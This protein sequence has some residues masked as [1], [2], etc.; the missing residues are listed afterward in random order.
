MFSRTKSAPRAFARLLA[1]ALCLAVWPLA[2]QA[3]DKSQQAYWAG[4]AYTADA[5]AVQVTTPH[6][7]AVLEKR[8]LIP[9]NQTLAQALKRRAPANLELIDQPVAMLDGTTSAVVL[10]AALDR[11]L[12]SVE[13]IGDQYKVLVE[14]A[15]QAL[16]FDFRERQVI[17]SY[18]LTLQRIDVQEYRPDSDDIDAIVADLL[19]GGAD[20]SLSQVLATTLAQAKLPEAA[21]RR[22]QVGAVTLSDATLAKLPDPKWAG[23]LRAT[24]AHELSKTLSS[25]TGV[26][27][28]P[29][30][31]GQAIG[32]AM[33]ARFADG[34]V[35]QLKIPEADYVISLQVDALKNGVI[36]ETPAMKT[37]LFGA[38]FTA[39]VTEPFSGKVYFEQPLRKGATKVVPVTQWQVDQWSASYET[40]L[41][42]F[43]AFAGAAAKPTDP[44]PPGVDQIMSLMRTILLILIALA[45]AS[46]VAAQTASSRGTGSASYSLRLSADTRAQALNKAK[47]NALEAY[48]AE[49]GA[50]KLR[51]FESR[52]AE[53]LGEI[54][55]Y[56]LSAVPLSDNEDKKAKTYSVTV[57][58]EINT[59]LLQ[60]KLD[61]GSAVAGATAAQR[62]LLTFLF[63]ARSQ[64]TVQSFQDK[65]YRRVDASSSYSENTREGDSFRGNSVST[66]GSINQNGSVSVTSGGSTTARS[67]NISWKVANAAE[68]NTAM[69]GAFSA[70]G[71]EVVEAEY[72]EGE[73]RGLLSIERIRKDFSTGNDLSAATLRDTANGIRAANIP[74]IAV[75]TLDVGMRD[76]DPA[77]GNTRVFVTVTGKVLDVTGRFPRTVSS[78]GPVQFSGT[79]PNETVARTNALQ[80]AA[81][82]AAQQMINELNVKAVR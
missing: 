22:L 25:N 47:A 28:L 37:M 51:L 58:A 60:T 53:F 36:S 77:S 3:A 26:G 5:A 4:F 38:F 43:D 15:L 24:L 20:T 27:L 82:K 76:R 18:P 50:A 68:V 34:K 61:A 72:V 64:D 44:S 10:A 70:A 45:V 40:L 81:E 12:V 67:D 1:Y 8:G 78:V 17:A 55:R 6:A 59:T 7:H 56:V 69:T 74:Y 42:G 49:S 31:S 29:P 9:L 71:Y 75:G 65:E 66:N 73:S 54:D 62:S 2:S 52:R 48:I 21:T 33:A 35:Y 80:L 14:V 46:P 39:K 30:A 11:E 13:P 63:M 19:Y 57:R 23:P 79:G 32:G 16:F 41:A